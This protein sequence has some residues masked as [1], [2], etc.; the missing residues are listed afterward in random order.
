[1]RGKQTIWK[2]IIPA[3]ILLIL[4][5]ASFAAYLNANRRMTVYRNAKYVE[6]AATQTANRIEDLLVSAENSI[7]A[8]AHMYE[9]TIDSERVNIDALQKI[10]DDTPFDYIGTAVRITSSKLSPYRKAVIASGTVSI[11]VSV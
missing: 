2:R 8:I 7:R 3:T 1:M 5:I 6:D 4:I 9:Q 10:V 11:Q